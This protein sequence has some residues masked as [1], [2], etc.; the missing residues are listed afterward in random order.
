MVSSEMLTAFLKVADGLSVSRAADD[1][2]VGKSVVSKRVAQLERSVG[3]TLFSRSTRRVA[4]T[5]SGEAYAEFARKALAEMTAGEER[6]R[7]MRSELSGSI[8]MTATVSWGQRVLAKALPEFLRLHPGIQIDLQLDDRM[9]DLARERIDIA[10]RWTAAP[11]RGLSVVP[12]ATVSWSLA[13]APS[14]LAGARALASPA[15]LTEHTCLCY[16]REAADDS[17]TLA[18]AGRTQHVRVRMR[19]HVDNPEAVADAALAGLGIAMLPDYLCEAALAEGR[20]VRVLP[21]W[22]PLTKFGTLITAVAAP[23]RLRL[24]RNQALLGF[25]RQQFGAP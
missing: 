23:E 10:L 14:Y 12:V 21:E 15:Q 8:R 13:A 22:T 24:P 19:Y 7:A 9:K 20:L 18:A 5:P 1:L 6:L 3:A 2:G 17:W 4:L 16:W 25:L 11:M